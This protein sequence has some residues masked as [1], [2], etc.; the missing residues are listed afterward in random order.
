MPGIKAVKR[1]YDQHPGGNLLVVGHT[2]TSGQDAYNLE[3]SL[4]R[5]DAMSAY[6]TDNVSAWEAFFEPSKP[7]QK[8]WGIRE[9]QFMLT[10]LPDGGEPFLAED[11]V[12]GKDGPVTQGAVKKFQQ[13]EG[14]KVDGIAGPNTRKALITRYMAIDGTSL[15]A[16]TEITTH[17]C[18]ENFPAAEVQ[19]GVRSPEDRRV[20]IFFFDGPID[21]PPP[22]K[23]SAKGSKEY[24]EW[25]EQVTQTLDFG[26]GAALLS[27]ALILKVGNAFDK[28]ELSGLEYRLSGVQFEESRPL[29][30]SGLIETEIP[31]DLTEVELELRSGQEVL[32]RNRFPIG[33]LPPVEETRGVKIRLNHLGFEAGAPEGDVDEIARVALKRFQ[34]RFGLEMTGQADA[35]TKS[36]LIEVYGS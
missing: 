28:G 14:L 36:K 20:E 12:D 3:L 8:R 18:G 32:F 29:D 22:A 11:Q 30:A 1:Q 2:D 13:G 19:D 26:D 15:P 27:R 16:G 34:Q 31:G 4:E 23:T 9:V 24:P 7:Q 25:V 10:R 5:A 33:D 6:L 17:G 21:P 35:G